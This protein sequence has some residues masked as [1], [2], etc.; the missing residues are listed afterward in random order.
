MDAYTTGKSLGMLTGVLI[1]LVLTVIILR[2]VNKDKKIMTE[3]DEMQKVVRGKGYKIAFY[4]AM[5]YEAILCIFDIGVNLPAEPVVVHFSTIFIGITVLSVYC[6]WK[7]AFVGLNTRLGRYIL[8][9]V[10]ISAINLLVAA[11]AWHEGSMYIGGKLQAPF[12]N[13][14]CGLLFAVIGVTGLIRKMQKQEES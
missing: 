7:D 13:F 11:F 10:F 3:Y 4:A 8:V 14:L 6:I 5:I 2:V 12:V 1:G 9:S